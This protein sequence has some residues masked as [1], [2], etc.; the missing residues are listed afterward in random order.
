MDSIALLDSKNKNIFVGDTIIDRLDYNTFLPT[1]MPSDFHEPEVL[2]IFQRSRDLRDKFNSISL[3]HFGVWVDENCDKI[4]NEMED[5]HFQTKEA[6][7][8]WYEEN[9]SMNHIASKYFDTFI[10]N[11]KI[12]S[13]EHL[14]GLKLQLEWLTRGLR[15]S[16][17]IS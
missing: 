10:P 13:K 9:P 1:F 12:F 3:A 14:R 7:I 17:F 11:S 4:L 15:S 16:G 2:K 6:I 8:K 5:L